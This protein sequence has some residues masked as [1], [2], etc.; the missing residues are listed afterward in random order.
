MSKRVFLRKAAKA[1]RE[2]KNL[3]GSQVATA[4][5]MSHAHYINIEAGRRQPT[6]EGLERIAAALGVE[7]DAISYKQ[8][9]AVAA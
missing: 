7:V 8:P 9:S 5:L 6:Q 2:A 3:P 4:C 1:I